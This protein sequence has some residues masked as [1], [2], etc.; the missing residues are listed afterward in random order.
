MVL[1]TRTKRSL[2][3]CFGLF[4]SH[5]LS[6]TKFAPFSRVSRL[7]L[8]GQ[9]KKNVD[10]GDANAKRELIL[11]ATLFVREMRDA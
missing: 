10:M 3:R 6:T 2:Q 4:L 11:F 1:D 5:L 8:Q 9:W 7:L